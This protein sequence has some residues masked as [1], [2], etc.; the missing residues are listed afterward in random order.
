VERERTEASKLRVRR[1]RRTVL[2]AA[3]AATAVKLYLAAKTYGSAD[4]YFFAAFARGVRHHGVYGVYTVKFHPVYNHPPLVG[5]LLLLLSHLSD[6]GISF[7]FLIRVPASL[8]DIAT[9][10]LV[11]ELVRSRRPLGEAGVAGV[12][13]GI[14]PALIVISGFHGN[15]DPVF[16]MFAVLSLYLLV[17]K[18]WGILAGVA[19]AAAISMKLVPIVCLPV[20]LL[21]AARKS[22][23]RL[24]E[25]VGGSGAFL[26][27][28]W[29]P[30]IIGYWQPFSKNVLGYKGV[31]GVPN[32]WGIIEFATNNLHWSRHALDLIE[33][34]GRWP[35]LLISAG[36]PLF[37]AWRRPS[38]AIPAFGMTLV[39][40]LLLNTAAS[41]GRYLVW[42]VA[43][44]FLV[45]VPTGALFDIGASVLLVVVY[46]RFNHGFPW[47]RAIG[48]PWTHV[49]TTIAGLTWFA[50]LA[51]VIRGVMNLR[52]PAPTVDVRE[53]ADLSAP[54]DGRA[55]D[56]PTTG[57]LT[58][59]RSLGTVV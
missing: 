17:I 45:D 32:K 49:E 42:A 56:G 6:L 37:V 20:L 7:R 1:L 4:I 46:N 47:D 51:V 31:A 21:I 33:G 16:V 39:L 25:F 9:T 11:F 43:A 18:D 3:L 27:L 2:I 50:L 35:M 19:F 53:T 44:A 13:L 54:D 22:R 15:T 48:G 28:L 59:S 10:M 38:A 34:P 30:A 5:W 8:A 23:R 14:S 36:L 55:P 29:L 12:L 58:Q 52:S 26:A 57:D 24:L 41:L 40:V